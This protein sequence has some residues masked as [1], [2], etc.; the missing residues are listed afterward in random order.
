MNQ[1][2]RSL[3][4]FP[5]L[6]SQSAGSAYDV[7]GALLCMMMFDRPTFWHIALVIDMVTSHSTCSNS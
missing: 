5:G 6:R 2:N 3:P 7:V 4:Q 1:V